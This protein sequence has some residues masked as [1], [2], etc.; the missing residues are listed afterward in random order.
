MSNVVH[1]HI[2]TSHSCWEIVELL[3]PTV[4]TDE[5]LAGRYVELLP[6]TEITYETLAGRYVELLPPTV[7][8]YETL[9][10]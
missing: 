1:V 7:I 8:T 10:G 3:L 2:I 9:A 6:P 5:T 4:I